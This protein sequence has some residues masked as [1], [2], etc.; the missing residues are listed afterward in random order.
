ML[1]IALR[2]RLR[3]YHTVIFSSL[4]MTRGFNAECGITVDFRRAKFFIREDNI[5]PYEDVCVLL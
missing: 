1:R 4:R 5:L 2:V 3:K